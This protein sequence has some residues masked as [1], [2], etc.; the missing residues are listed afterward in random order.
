MAHLRSSKLIASLVL[1][2]FALFLGS[3]IASSLI[4]PGSMQVICAA[5]GG[6]KLVQTDAEE[7][8]VAMTAGLDCPLCASVFAP[9][10][11]TAALFQKRSPL[12]TALQSTAAARIVSA[13]A[14]PLPA[15]GPPTSAS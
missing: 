4:K 13:T 7:G 6:M 8:K 9:V 14:P 15:R 2:L 3:A 1:A 10:P 12:A 5:G 11:D